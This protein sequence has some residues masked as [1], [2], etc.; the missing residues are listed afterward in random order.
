MVKAT[1]VVVLVLASGL[2]IA[3]LALRRRLL[4]AVQLH[5]AEELDV[6]LE[7]HMVVVHGGRRRR[8]GEVGL[9]LGAVQ[10]AGLGVVGPRRLLRRV[11]RSDSQPAAA[12]PRPSGPDLRRPPPG[13][14]PLDAA[15]VGPH[16]RSAAA[17]HHRH[18]AGD[19][20]ILIC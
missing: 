14:A 8:R 20:M 6:R 16:P 18:H 7:V 4:I 12:A 9:G 17:R 15:E 5:L 1:S 3:D 10:P 19:E 11:V 13:L 2:I